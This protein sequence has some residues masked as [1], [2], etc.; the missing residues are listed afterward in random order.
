MSLIPSVHPRQQDRMS[1]VIAK[2]QRRLSWVQLLSH[3]PCLISSLALSHSPRGRRWS[4]KQRAKAAEKAE[5]CWQSPPSCARRAARNRVTISAATC[6][7]ASKLFTPS[8]EIL[9]VTCTH[10]SGVELAVMCRSGEGGPGGEVHSSESS[11]PERHAGGAEPSRALQV[12]SGSPLSSK[13]PQPENP[14]R[15]IGL[16]GL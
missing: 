13:A 3:L 11:L 5:F 4:F 1:H 9:N 14:N 16:L 7:S 8:C 12:D 6:V 15:V 10:S 2:S